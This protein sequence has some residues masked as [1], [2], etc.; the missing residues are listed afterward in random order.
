MRPSVSLVSV[1]PSPVKPPVR[2]LPRLAFS[3]G[4][5]LALVWGLLSLRALPVSAQNQGV[6]YIFAI[7]GQAERKSAEQEAFER[8][9]VGDFLRAQDHLQV[10]TSSTVEVMCNDG[11]P[12]SFSAGTY[13]VGDYCASASP[14]LRTPQRQPA[15]PIQARIPYVVRPRNTGLLDEPQPLIRWNPVVGAQRYTVHVSG[16]EVAWSREVVGDSQ[17]TYEGPPLRPDERYRI[18]ITADTQLSSSADEPVGFTLLSAAEADRVKAQ[19]AAL[20]TELRA[21]GADADAEALGLALL[22]HGYQ[23]RDPEQGSRNGLHQAALEVLQARIEAGSKNSQVYRLQ[24]D[25]YAVM[26]LPLKAQP[27]YEQALARA[28]A[29]GQWGR[30]AVLHE[31]LAT[32]AQ[33]ASDVAAAISHLEAARALYQEHGHVTQVTALQE[34]IERLQPQL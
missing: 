23:P 18:V 5:P 25:I 26:G 7:Q 12:R 29:A 31:Q 11:R 13:T 1:C 34:Q 9:D 27:L 32:V 15:R 10:R 20:Q 3:A 16:P 4:L 2:W 24:G 28:Q 21:A 17:V 30:Q 6:N 14:S 22:Y 19:A 8:A 33:D